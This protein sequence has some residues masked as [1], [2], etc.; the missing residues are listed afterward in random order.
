MNGLR[1]QL[2]RLPE[3]E[4]PA[5]LAADVAARIARLDNERV[6]TGAQR[7]RPEPVRPA[8]EQLAWAAVIGGTAIGFAAQTYRLATGEV[9]PSWLGIPAGRVIEGFLPALSLS[10]ATAV[11]AVGLALYVAGLFAPLRGG[12][13]AG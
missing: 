5:H 9:A 6:T 3:P 4:P 11:L 7:G 13:D 10:P 1:S 12:R 8:R 2:Q